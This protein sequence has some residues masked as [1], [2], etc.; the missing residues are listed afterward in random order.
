MKIGLYSDSARE[1]I[2]MVRSEIAMDPSG[3]RDFRTRIMSSGRD[4]HK[5]I[6][7][8]SDFYNT[9]NLRDLLFHVQ[10]H[11][12]S[13]PQIGECLNELGLAFCGFENQAIIRRFQSQF[14]SN[15]ALYDLAKWHSFEKQYP[16]TFL[17]M[18]QFWCQKIA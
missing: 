8:S 3:I 11:R 13:I 2:A 14:G 4:H 15:D 7:R 12:F 9:S 5:K 10:E 16:D 18:Y 1:H 6:A 17:G